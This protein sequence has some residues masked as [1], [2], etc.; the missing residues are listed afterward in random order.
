MT[1]IKDK[2]QNIK[3]ELI[4]LG[5]CE[6]DNLFIVADFIRLGYF[7]VNGLLSAQDVLQVL[8]EIIGPNGNIITPSYT[9]TDY[10]WGR[11]LPHFDV[12]NVPPNNAFAQAI[13]SLSE[14]QNVV[15]SKHPTNSY[16]AIG[17]MATDLVGWHNEKYL[18][19]APMVLLKGMNFKNLL[20]AMGEDESK[21]L[22]VL[23]AA[24][25]YLG[26]STKNYLSGLLAAKYKSSEGK[27]VVYRRKSVGGCTLG[28][29]KAVGYLINKTKSKVS[30]TGRGL[31]ILVEWDYA[32]NWHV[33]MLKND[34]GYFKCHDKACKS[35][36]GSRGYSKRFI[37]FWLKWIV[38]IL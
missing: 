20:L 1:L 16:I 24:Q 27:T 17:P 10:I 12:N 36:H 13:F 30:K 4:E 35:C 25:E 18:A 31:S 34:R 33:E 14:K 22:S 38:N 7:R 28:G 26:M 3:L 23:H 37:F 8:L 19:Y 29:K 15:R 6:G 11:E 9:E 2:L 5:V 32:F 21:G